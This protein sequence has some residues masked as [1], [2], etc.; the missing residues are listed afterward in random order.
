MEDQIRRRTLFRHPLAAVGGALFL[1]GGF[2]FV[3]LLLMDLTG[4]EENPYRA[5]V[6]FVL[7]P[8][9]VTLGLVLFLISAWF[10]V[11]EARKKGEKVK[12]RLSIEPTD[13]S[14]MKNLWLFLAISAVLLFL[15]GYSGTRAFEATDSVTFCGET[16]HTVMEPQ[17]VTYHGSPHARVKCVDCHIGPG[18]SFW[19]KS[20][21]DGLRQVVATARNSYSR[22]IPTPVHNLRPA[23]QTCEECHW[24]LQ[25]YGNKMV[26]RTYY[27]TDEANSPWSTHLLLKIGGGNPRA[28]QEGGIHWHMLNEN[29]VEY[30]AVDEKRRTI[31]WVR[32]TNADGESTVYQNGDVDDE[33]GPEDSGVE[34]RRFDCM[35]CHN[36]PSHIFLPPA[37]AINLAL[38][39]RTLSP[40]LPFIRKV[41]LDLLNAEHSTREEARE[42]IR[43]GLPA[44]YA[45]Q[46]PELARS[47][48][49]DIEKATE[50]LLTIYQENFFPEMKTDY[51]ARESHLSHF[52]NDGCFRCHNESMVDDSGNHL[53]YDCQTCHL[54]VAQGPSESVEE[55]E[56]NLAGLDFKHPEDIDEMWRDMKCTECHTPEA[57]Y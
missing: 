24:P 7:A 39:G 12:F 27:R 48:N 9:I 30:I 2:F 32:T 19:V 36:R 54:I 41:G 20:K 31:A 1:A 57:G 3:I 14:Y 53:A 23:Q 13:P 34:V 50:T 52:V 56:M 49:Q 29:K 17:N 28:Q 8:A 46:Y 5:L 33:V 26:R 6:T 18:A 47:M 11:K 42:A 38:L 37:V 55:L 10:Q 51:R 44:Y 43:S 15:V 45:E 4:G 16:C 22:P 21:I 40:E 35:D 25:F